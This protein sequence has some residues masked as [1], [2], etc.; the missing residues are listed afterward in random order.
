MFY[1]VIVRGPG[2]F[3]TALISL[4]LPSLF[5]ATVQQHEPFTLFVIPS[6]GR[7]IDDGQLYHSASQ[8]VDVQRTPLRRPTS[9]PV[10]A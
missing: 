3:R 6:R 8:S 10:I 1:F 2:C 7:T 4:H 5:T 9:E